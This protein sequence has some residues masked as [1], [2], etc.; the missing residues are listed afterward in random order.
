MINY[1]VVAENMN[2]LKNF[3]KYRLGY[4]KT[5]SFYKKFLLRFWVK[6]DFFQK[7]PQEDNFVDL[8]LGFFSWKRFNHFTGKVI[9]N[10][11]WPIFGHISI[12]LMQKN[13]KMSFFEF[14][15][16]IFSKNPK[17]VLRCFQTRNWLLNGF[18]SPQTPF[19]DHL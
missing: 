12:L 8:L 17:M 4:K 6:N 10:V 18:R 3:S 11:K 19:P 2:F 9:S 5:L 15:K 16:S 14:K 1:E 7:M 13:F